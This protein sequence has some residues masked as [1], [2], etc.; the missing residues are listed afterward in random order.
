MF[1]M[2]ARLKIAPGLPLVKACEGDRGR[3]DTVL[4]SYLHLVNLGMSQ[5]LG[6]K[7][8]DN[9]QLTFHFTLLQ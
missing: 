4:T 5:G 6:V 8:V 2:E 1:A 9:R 3:G 7:E